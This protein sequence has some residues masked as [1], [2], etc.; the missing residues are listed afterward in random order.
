MAKRSLI[1]LHDDIM[2]VFPIILCK[3]A[4]TKGTNFNRVAK[5]RA[6]PMH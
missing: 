1:R 2:M 6:R 4:L 5:R 3:N